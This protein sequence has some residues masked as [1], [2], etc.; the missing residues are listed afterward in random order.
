MTELVELAGGQLHR[1]LLR[2]GALGR[3][4]DREVATTLVAPENVPARLFDVE[5]ELRDQDHVRP[6]GDA[7]M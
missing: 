7:G 5:R 6:A 1:A 3:D 2:D 4:D